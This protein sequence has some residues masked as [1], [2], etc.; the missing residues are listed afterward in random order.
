MTSKNNERKIIILWVEGTNDELAWQNV[1]NNLLKEQ[2]EDYEKKY[3]LVPFSLPSDNDNN[4]RNEILAD[5]F[6]SN[7]FKFKGTSNSIS[8]DLSADYQVNPDNIKEKIIKLVINSQELKNKF[9]Q[10]YQNKIAQI[11]HI[12][13]TDAAWVDLSNVVEDKNLPK[14]FYGRRHNKY[15][16]NKIYTVNVD[17]QKKNMERKRANVKKLIKFSIE[18]EKFYKSFYNVFFCSCNTDHVICGHRNIGDKKNNAIEFDMKYGNDLKMLRDFFRGANSSNT[19][20]IDEHNDWKVAT[21]NLTTINGS[22]SSERFTTIDK[23]AT[24]VKANLDSF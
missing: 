16:L 12:I 17:A 8:G 20:I 10:S 23:I 11:I 1:V 22:K 4:R 15:G 5:I 7:Q 2:I 13:D 21:Q 18:K 14:D 3:F 24:V 6:G 9:G 19:A